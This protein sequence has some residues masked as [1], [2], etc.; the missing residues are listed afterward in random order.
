MPASAFFTDWNTQPTLVRQRWVCLNCTHTHMVHNARWQPSPLM[1][2]YAATHHNER[3]FCIQFLFQQFF[4][5]RVTLTLAAMLLVSKTEV[6]FK[7]E[8][9]SGTHS[10]GLSI[11]KWSS[12]IIQGYKT[13]WRTNCIPQAIPGQA[14]WERARQQKSLG[15]TLAGYAKGPK[16]T[17]WALPFP[18]TEI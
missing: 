5:D 18:G 16:C 15:L 6:R 3:H 4:P 2:N 8:W 13:G 14:L 11:T 12:Q 9:D 1:C 17:N 10:V 7:G